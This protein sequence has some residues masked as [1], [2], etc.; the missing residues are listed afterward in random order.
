[1]IS[2]LILAIILGA[3]GCDGEEGTPTATPTPTL[4]SSNPPYTPSNPLPVDAADGVSITPTLSWTGGDPDGDPVVYDVYLG[5]SDPLPLLPL[6]SEEQSA[7]SYTPPEPLDTDTEYYWRVVCA[8]A[9]DHSS[10]SIGPL[11]EFTTETAAN[12]PPNT[13]SSQSPA[14]GAT[15]GAL[16]IGLGKGG[17]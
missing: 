9:A 15:T 6:A 5:T 7:T 17:N 4:T 1:M 13:P 11:W 3:V 10:Y 12:N 2:L 14:A 8:E 16:G